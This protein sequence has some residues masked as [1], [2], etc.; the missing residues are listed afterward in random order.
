MPEI[1]SGPRF[2]TAFEEKSVPEHP[3]L[4]ELIGWCR[5]MSFLGFA[6]SAEDS[7]CAGNLSFRTDSGFIITGAGTNMGKI[8][9]EEFAEVISVEPDKNRVVVHGLVEPSSETIL[10]SFIYDLRPEINAVFH[11]H[12]DRMLKLNVDLALPETEQEIQYGTRELAESGAELIKWHDFIL[13]KDHGFISVG[14]TMGVAGEQLLEM[15]TR[16]N[17]NSR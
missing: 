10:H 5:R 1:Y 12:D 14:P 2:E 7:G 11:G 15:L 3:F 4:G 13:L 8:T 9:P 6:P 17:R 16:M